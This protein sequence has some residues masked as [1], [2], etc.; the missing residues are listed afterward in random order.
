MKKHKIFL[1]VIILCVVIS[2]FKINL[3]LNRQIY[4]SIVQDTNSENILYKKNKECY[5]LDNMV[6]VLTYPNKYDIKKLNTGDK[7]E[8][9]NIPRIRILFNR[10]PFDFRIDTNK[11]IFFLNNRVLSNL[12]NQFENNVMSLKKFIFNIG[13]SIK[14][15]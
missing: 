5:N 6:D 9:I 2:I 4:K 14:K 12:K 15:R 1:L 7:E 8:K 11:Y 3:N 13:S 10:K